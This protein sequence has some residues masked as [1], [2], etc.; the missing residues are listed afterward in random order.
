[1]MMISMLKLDEAASKLRESHIIVG[2]GND[3][4][5]KI[6]TTT[7][8]EEQH[9]RVGACLF[10]V[11]TSSFTLAAHSTRRPRRP[12]L[13]RCRFAGARVAFSAGA[14]ARLSCE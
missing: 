8:E 5:L 3:G 10:S 6:V 14:L 2:T 1:M 12:S 4:I 9:A 11:V 13:R 7:H